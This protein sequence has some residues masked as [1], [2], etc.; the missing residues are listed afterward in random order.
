MHPADR[1]RP[2]APIFVVG[3][4]RSGT[5]LLRLLLNAHS[6][7]AIPEELTYFNEVLAGVPL[8][9]WRAPD[10]TPDQYHAFV[11]GFL[12]RHA[13]TLAPLR[14]D[15]LEAEILSHPGIDLRRPYQTALEAWA[16]CHGKARWGEKTPGNLFYAHV[17]LDMFPEARFIYLV[18]DPRAGVLS[19]TRASMFADDVVINALNRRRYAT[20]GGTRLEQAVPPAQRMTLRYE[21]LVTAPEAAARTLCAFLGEPFEP[22]ML[23]FHEEARQYMAPHAATGFNRAATRPISPARVD[24]WRDWLRPEDVALIEH[25]C[26]DEMDRFG[27]AREAGVALPL[28]QRLDVWAKRGYLRLQCRRHPNAPQYLLKHRMFDRSRRRLRR[29]RQ[30]LT[31]WPR[32]TREVEQP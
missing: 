8:R 30:H 9:T 3:A 7:I 17:I 4:N 2:A 25:I 6:R 20:E 22:D 1:Q 21:D 32:T 27:Y 10:L 29:A 19:M 24:E 13:G 16:R 31:T 14:V 23:R 5:T 18:R 26:A 11:R 15:D 12:R 28:A